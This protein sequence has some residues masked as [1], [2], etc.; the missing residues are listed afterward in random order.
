MQKPEHIAIIMDGNGRWAQERGLQRF[1]GHIA[2]ARTVEQIVEDADD[3][4]VKQLTLYC[5]SSENWKRPKAELDALMILLK[6]YVIDQRPR[7]MEKSV[8]F[9]VIGRRKGIPDD[10]LAEIDKTIELTR[11]NRGIILCLAINYGSR[12]ELRDAFVQ[13][14][15]QLADPAS[16]A[17]LLEENH[18]G[19][20]D[21]LITEEFISRHLYTAPYADPDLLIRT[22]GEMRLSNYLLWQISYAELW[23]TPIYWPDFNKKILEEAIDAFGKRNRKFGGLPG[24]NLP[25]P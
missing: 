25:K 22:A 13:M 10:V 7:M 14:A 17:A 23:I 19:S 9:K 3:L 15:E 21:E 20:I 12:G 4:G 6:N 2:G 11:R 8:Q 24:G 18:A 16:R 5:L 1:E